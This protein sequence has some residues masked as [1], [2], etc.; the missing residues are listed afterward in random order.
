VCETCMRTRIREYF[1]CL[2]P[3]RGSATSATSTPGTSATRSAGGPA[4]GSRI[5]RHPRRSISRPAA[6][7]RAPAS[8][9][10]ESSQRRDTTVVYLIVEHEMD[11]TPH[12][13]G[14]RGCSPRP[15]SCLNTCF[16][17]YHVYNVGMNTPALNRRPAPDPCQSTS[18]TGSRGARRRAR[19]LRQRT[20]CCSCISTRRLA[21]AFADR[22]GRAPRSQPVP[23]SRACLHR[24]RKSV[25][26]PRPRIRATA[27]IG[28]V[29]CSPQ[30]AAASQRK[31]RRPSPGSLDSVRRS[32]TD[33]ELELWPDCL[34]A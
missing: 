10:H 28:Y 14:R 22:P 17:K 6:A 20:E 34:G 23:A 15:D 30:P 7:S 26:R 5:E 3:N 25:G 27:A 31:A 21:A 4:C 29:P 24:W 32:L 8:P 12:G 11:P 2:V 13:A 33:K 19:P 9:W 16:R 18:R 1:R